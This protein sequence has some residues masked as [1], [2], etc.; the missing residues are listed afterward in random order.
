[1]APLMEGCFFMLNVIKAPNTWEANVMMAFWIR[2]KT[3]AAHF[4]FESL[5]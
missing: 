4:I 3:I 2:K 1:M 5:E